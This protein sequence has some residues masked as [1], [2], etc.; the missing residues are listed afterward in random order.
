MPHSDVH[1]DRL[2]E[3]MVWRLAFRFWGESYALVDVREASTG[4]RTSLL[5]LQDCLLELRMRGVQL[6]LP[7][8]ECEDIAG[9]RRVEDSVRGPR[10]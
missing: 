3:R 8:R 1:L 5:R 2:D 4:L 6:P 10:D 9:E 7:L